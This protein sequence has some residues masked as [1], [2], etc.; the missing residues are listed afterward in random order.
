M[1]KAISYTFNGNSQRVAQYS[2]GFI[3][4]CWGKFGRKKKQKKWKL[5]T[6]Y[7]YSSAEVIAEFDNKNNLEQ[8]YTMG[9]VLII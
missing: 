3:W 7:V 4:D 8:I 6:S 1:A 2:K 9:P 5:D